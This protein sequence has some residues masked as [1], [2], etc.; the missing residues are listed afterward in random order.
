MEESKI[1][2]I[3]NRIKVCVKSD[4]LNVAKELIKIEIENL[5]GITEQRCKNTKYY[6]YD[7]YCKYCSNY[8]CNSNKNLDI[9]QFLKIKKFD[10]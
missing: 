6:F 4:S 1:L 5:K 3:L 10:F 2:E 7:T 9:S 8:N